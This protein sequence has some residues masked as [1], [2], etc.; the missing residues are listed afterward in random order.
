MS[1]SENHPAIHTYTCLGSQADRQAGRQTR[2][3]Q[4]DPYRRKRASLLTAD[5]HP[6]W[7]IRRLVVMPSCPST[8][9]HA[10]TTNAPT[11]T[12]RQ[13]SLPLFPCS[14]VL[15]PLNKQGC[16]PLPPIHSPNTHQQHDFC[17][18]PAG[19]QEADGLGEPDDADA[20]SERR[21]A[22]GQ[23]FGNVWPVHRPRQPYR[24]LPSRST[25]RTHRQHGAGAVR[26]QK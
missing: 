21:R 5:R 4:A 8:K 11:E 17:P 18:F 24:P 20:R 23:A 9:N 2:R 6:T 19:L 7:T 15:T 3:M 25:A 16:S 10:H 12:D 26:Q 13:R 14:K 22:E 1:A